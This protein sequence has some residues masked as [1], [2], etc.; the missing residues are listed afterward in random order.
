MTSSLFP[1]QRF[2]LKILSFT[3]LLVTAGH[4]VAGRR[5]K[6]PSQHH[7]R[8]VLANETAPTPAPSGLQYPAPTIFNAPKQQTATIIMLHGLGQRS[9]GWNH[10]AE[11]Y[12]EQLPYVKWIFPNAPIVRGPQAVLET[13]T[14]S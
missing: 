14:L 6:H 7:A 1:L 11:I 2:Q 3:L 5:H 12:A 8:V 13:E 9:T 10:W 4:V